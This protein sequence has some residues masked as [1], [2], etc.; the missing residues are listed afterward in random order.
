MGEWRGEGEEKEE[1]GLENGEYKLCLAL[2]TNRDNSTSDTR[3]HTQAEWDNK[4]RNKNSTWLR[5]MEWG[6][7]GGGSRGKG[8]EASLTNRLAGH[9]QCDNESDPLYAILTMQHGSNWTDKKRE[10]VKEKERERERKKENK[11]REV[12][13]LKKVTSKY[14]IT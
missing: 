1:W 4:Q 5:E 12:G 6:K 14:N 7:G 13:V 9:D 10:W 8:N 2:Q 3:T 11:D